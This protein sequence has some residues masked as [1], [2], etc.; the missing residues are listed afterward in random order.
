MTW[1]NAHDV[2]FDVLAK[3]RQHGSQPIIK[4]EIAWFLASV[5]HPMVQSAGMDRYT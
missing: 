5:H 3:A 4:T 1:N 2:A